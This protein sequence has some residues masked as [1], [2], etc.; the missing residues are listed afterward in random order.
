[1]PC[2]CPEVFAPVCGAD[3]NTYENECFAACAGVGVAHAG[4]CGP[5]CEPVLC[6]LFC[7]NGFAR[8]ENGCDVCRCAEPPD[9]Q[10]SADGDC[11]A[12]QRCANG[13]CV[14]NDCICPAV[15]MPV[16]GTDGMTYGNAC[17]AACAGVEVAHDGECGGPE[18]DLCPD[19]NAPGVRYVSDDPD[20]CARADFRCDAGEQQFSNECGCGC[21][22]PAEP[23]CPDPN[24][25]AVHYISDD[26]EFCARARFVCEDGQ[27]SF[28]NACGCGC[29]A[30]PSCICPRVFMPVCGGD[31]MT[32]GNACEAACAGVEV[33]HAGECGAD[34]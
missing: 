12:G 6:D 34:R 25:P 17:G 26:P 22:G 23:I 9:V 29:I 31:G 7:E 4:E 24:D 33:V 27:E 21:I 8:D 11:A 14:N 2:V 13:R 10:C 16:C 20:V 18:P 3:G 28:S 32:Y 19:P 30:M 1:M 15:F 5:A